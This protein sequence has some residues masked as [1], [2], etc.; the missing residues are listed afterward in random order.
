MVSLPHGAGGRLRRTEVA[1][2]VVV[3]AVV[4]QYKQIEFYF[5]RPLPLPLP[6]L[7]PP[8]WC[9]AGARVTAHFMYRWFDTR[10]KSATPT[11]C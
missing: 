1:T 11:T 4:F 2:I 7:W 9:L 6:V 3:I 5:G 10:M 8:W